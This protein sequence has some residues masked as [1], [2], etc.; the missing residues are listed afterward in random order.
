[1]FVCGGAVMVRERCVCGRAVMV[2]GVCACVW[3][4]SDS[5]WEVCLCVEA[6]G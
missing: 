5:A 1:M 4:G 3:G 2:L 6:D